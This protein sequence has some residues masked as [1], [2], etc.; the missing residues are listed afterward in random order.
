MNALLVAQLVAQ[1]GLPLAQ[2]LFTMY[3]NGNQP[4]TQADFDALTKL[5]QYRSSDA[6]AAA[7]I[8]I[9][10]GKVVPISS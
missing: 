1:Y 8:N 4:V 5:S 2:Q 3:Q 6:L 9:V 7:G 10:D